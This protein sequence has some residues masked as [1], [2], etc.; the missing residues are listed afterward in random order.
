MSDPIFCLIETN[1]AALVLANHALRKRGIDYTGKADVRMM[2]TI[3][4]GEIQ[5]IRLEVRLDENVEDNG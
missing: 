2:T 1:E 3:V 5:Q 4:K